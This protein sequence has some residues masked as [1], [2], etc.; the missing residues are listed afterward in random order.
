M[1]F[2]ETF[3]DAILK[4]LDTIHGYAKPF[5]EIFNHGDEKVNANRNTFPLNERSTK[6]IWNEST[7]DSIGYDDLL[8]DEFEE[9]TI[10]NRSPHEVA[11]HKRN[12]S[13][14][15]RASKKQIELARKNGIELDENQTYVNTYKTGRGK[16]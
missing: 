9:R 3:F 6:S 13:N 15:R 10:I 4:S 11:S 8:E 1:S 12:L 16:R 2:F 7:D 14:G 5:F